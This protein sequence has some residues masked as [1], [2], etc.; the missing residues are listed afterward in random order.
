MKKIRLI[1]SAVLMMT[2]F[3]FIACSHSASGSNGSGGSNNTSTGN[4]SQYQIGDIVLNDGSDNFEQI[5]ETASGV[6]VIAPVAGTLLKQYFSTGTKVTNGQTV[7]IIESMKME[8]E[9][10][11]TADGTITYIIAPGTRINNGQILASIK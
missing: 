9:V 4:I 6:P 11:A 7:I 10:K 2:A 8:L 5:T 1:F 3:G